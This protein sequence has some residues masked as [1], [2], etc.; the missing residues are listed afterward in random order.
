MIELF[1]QLPSLAPLSRL[2]RSSQAILIGGLVWVGAY[3]VVAQQLPPPLIR[4]EDPA[5]PVPTYNPDSA[6]QPR[7]LVYIYGDSPL[8]LGAIQRLAPGATLQRYG[9]ENIIQVGVFNSATEARRQVE[10]LES[11]GFIVQLETLSTD[12]LASLLQPPQLGSVSS[13]LRSST[14]APQ[15]AFSSGVSALPPAS[16]FGAPLPNYLVY[17]DNSNPQNL[18]RVQQ[19]VPDAFRRNLGRQTVIQV[20]AFTDEFNARQ[21]VRQLGAQGVPAQVGRLDGSSI[22]VGQ[23][24]L[25]ATREFSPVIS[26]RA[27]Y[28]VIPAG[29][30]NFP[31]LSDRLNQVIRGEVPFQP[32]SGP[33]GSHLAVG[34]FSDRTEAERWNRNLQTAGISNT[35]V[36]Y[37]R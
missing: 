22:S 26:S 11:Q 8:L 14:V 32:R 33:F 21:W 18:A 1:C 12:A 34:P 36:Y 15:P 10:S 37:G 5:F 20:G 30:E 29:Q 4:G 35:R 24:P 28:V 16:R 17:V 31:S 19:V 25:P 9:N 3:P 23:T 2:L 13:T 27:Y 7:Y 6:S